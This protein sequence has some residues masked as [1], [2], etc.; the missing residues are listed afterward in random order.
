M[1][2][3]HPLFFKEG[4]RK[5]KCVILVFMLENIPFWNALGI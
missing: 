1:K 2:T 5:A 3:R 4:S